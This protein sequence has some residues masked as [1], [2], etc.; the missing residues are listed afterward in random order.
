M[1][2]PAVSADNLEEFC[3]YVPGEYVRDRC[4]FWRPLPP[5]LGPKGGGANE[6]GVKI[7]INSAVH[8]GLSEWGPRIGRRKDQECEVSGMSPQIGP[9]RPSSHSIA[10]PS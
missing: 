3:S 4:V 2:V 1:N 9:V 7:H 5:S 6:F 10:H 8:P